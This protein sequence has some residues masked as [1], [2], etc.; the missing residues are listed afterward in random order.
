MELETTSEGGVLVVMPEG[1]I[2]GFN[3]NEFQNALSAMIQE[4]DSAL[5]MD[6]ERLTYISSAGLRV[7]L[8][9]AKNLQSQDKKLL[10]CSL[11]D[12]VGEVFRV[13]GFDRII[14]THNTRTDAA[15]SLGH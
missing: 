4:A 9:V 13:S 14:E 11:S 10:L 2:D 5:V 6:M 8:Q 3:S 12:A 1:R 15:A 7:I